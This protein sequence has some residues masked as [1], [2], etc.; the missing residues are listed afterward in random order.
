MMG[1]IER[2]EARCPTKSTCAA[3]H[4]NGL[5]VRRKRKS[6]NSSRAA[7]DAERGEEARKWRGGDT[8]EVRV[9]N[10]EVWLNWTGNEALGG[11]GRPWVETRGNVQRASE[12]QRGGVPSKRQ[13]RLRLSEAEPVLRAVGVPCCLQR[14]EDQD[15]LGLH[16]WKTLNAITTEVPR[17]I[18]DTRIERGCELHWNLQWVEKEDTE[19]KEWETLSG[20]DNFERY[21]SRV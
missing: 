5:P 6:R 3:C 19:A 1:T 16:W 12:R 8:E 14:M 9:M 18:G 10:H 20:W 17:T 15:V 4:R 11:H 7:W 2:T 13:W 21:F